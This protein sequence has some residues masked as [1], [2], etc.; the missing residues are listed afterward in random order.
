MERLCVPIHKEVKRLADLHRKRW[1]PRMVFTE[2]N[3]E[4]R[5]A[6]FASDDA[7]F[8]GV[9]GTHLCAVEASGWERHK[10]LAPVEIDG[11]H[12]SHYWQ[13]AHS[14]RPIGGTPGVAHRPSPRSQPSKPGVTYWIVVSESSSTFCGSKV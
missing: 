1:T 10:F 12:Y 5:A 4:F 3:H 13:N 9:V 6:R 11:V 7:R 2:G 14:N 8:D